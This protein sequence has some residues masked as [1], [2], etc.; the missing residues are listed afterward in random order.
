MNK[1]TS[2]TDCPPKTE[3]IERSPQCRAS[4][5]RVHRRVDGDFDRDLDLDLDLDRDLDL[6]PPT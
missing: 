3:P 2:N 4:P 1:P 5:N 6:R